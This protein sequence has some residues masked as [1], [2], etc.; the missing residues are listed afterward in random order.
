MEGVA[1]VV[2][3]GIGGAVMAAAVMT[4][5]EV[6]TAPAVAAAVVIEMAAAGEVVTAVGEVEMASAGE[7]ETAVTAV[8]R[9]DRWQASAPSERLT[10][11]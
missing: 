7:I 4:A 3:K 6:E 8:G 11:F 1:G 5:G 10:R 9:L 2:G